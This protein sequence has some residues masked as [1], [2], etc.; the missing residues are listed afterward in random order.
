MKHLLS[1]TAAEVGDEEED[2]WRNSGH[3][4][5]LLAQMCVLVALMTKNTFVKL[6][7]STQR[8]TSLYTR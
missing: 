2:V 6:V 5:Y 8:E 1:A 4:R 7:L 3:N